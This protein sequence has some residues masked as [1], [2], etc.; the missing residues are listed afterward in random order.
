MQ[1][2][3]NEIDSAATGRVFTRI[4]PGVALHT[5]KQ[6]SCLS[7]SQSTRCPFYLQASKCFTPQLDNDRA[8][9]ASLT[10]RNMAEVY[11][12]IGQCAAVATALKVLLWPS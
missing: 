6:V 1:F 5:R 2:M 8:T 12:T 7:L 4:L 11:P 10:S 9:I 3:A